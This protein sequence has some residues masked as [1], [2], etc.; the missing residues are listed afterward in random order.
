MTDNPKDVKMDFTMFASSLMMEGLAALGL[1]KHP[2]AEKIQKD[3]Q[4][5]GFVIETLDMLREKTQGNLSKEESDSLNESI[6]Q[7]RLAYVAVKETEDRGQKAE[8]RGQK[9]EDRGQKTEKD[10][11]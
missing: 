3:L 2:I 11:K 1:V 10:E 8:D 5:A 7:L 4:H 6:H 9:A